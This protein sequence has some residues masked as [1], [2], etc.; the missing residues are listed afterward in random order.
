MTRQTLK[1]KLESNQVNVPDDAFE[2]MSNKELL[3]L[4]RLAQT[5]RLIVDITPLH[6]DGV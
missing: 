4:I 6:V 2:R 3:S 5:H 1:L